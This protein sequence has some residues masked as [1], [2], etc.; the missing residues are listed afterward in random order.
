MSLKINKIRN[1]KDEKQNFTKTIRTLLIILVGVQFV[2]D[3]FDPS[4]SN[5]IRC[6][7]IRVFLDAENLEYTAKGKKKGKRQ[8]TNKTA[9]KRKRK[10]E[11]Q[12]SK[13][14]RVLA[15]YN[16]DD[17]QRGGYLSLPLTLLPRTA[18]GEPPPRDCINS[19]RPLPPRLPIYTS[20]SLLFCL[21]LASRPLSSPP[22]SLSLSSLLK[23]NFRRQ[24]KRIGVVYNE[25]RS[26]VS[27]AAPFS[28]RST[29][30]KEMPVGA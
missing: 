21:F 4:F 8:E 28:C 25:A 23:H 1:L 24:T 11:S 29:S 20:L 7:D 17:K 10:G 14:G 9:A 13:R 22:F 30:R 6:L 3:T 26:F 18:S 12:H 5:S 19:S 16:F 27:S 2:T 15:A